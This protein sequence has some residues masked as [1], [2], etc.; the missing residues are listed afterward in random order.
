MFLSSYH[1]PL[2]LVTMRLGVRADD[3]SIL[4]FTFVDDIDDL[5]HLLGSFSP[6]F[7]LGSCTS[8][9]LISS[10]IHAQFG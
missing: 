1:P 3:S 7:K 9:P 5:N 10:V 6:S 2:I 4:I 8:V